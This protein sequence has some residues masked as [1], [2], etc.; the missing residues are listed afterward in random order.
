M[1]GTLLG[2]SLEASSRIDS[3]SLVVIGESELPR[4][5]YRVHAG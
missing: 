5:Y 1:S 4:G 3:V 2:G